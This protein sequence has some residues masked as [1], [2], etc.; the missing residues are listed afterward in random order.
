MYMNPISF[1]MLHS[2]NPEEMKLCTPLL[3]MRYPNVGIKTDD[4]FLF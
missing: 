3:K 1:K 2:I 4:G